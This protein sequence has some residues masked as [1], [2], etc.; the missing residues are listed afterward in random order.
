MTTVQLQGFANK[1]LTHPV[2]VILKPFQV[3]W[4]AYAGDQRTK[5]NAG[6]VV[7]TPDYDVNPAALQPDLHA[8]IASCLCELATSIYLNQRWNGPYWSPKHHSEA[9]QIPDIGRDIEVRRTRELGRGIPVF[10]REA[11]RE[12]RLV[13]AYITPEELDRVLGWAAED[14]DAFDFAAIVLTGT[15]PAAVAWKNGEQLYPN[16][17]VCPARY[18]S[19]IASLTYGK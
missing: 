9:K 1:L 14:N 4:A 8:N 5:R 15:V 12:F 17:R 16:K 10:E 7:N 11:E 18:F 19:S 6:K 13:Q 2:S 3:E